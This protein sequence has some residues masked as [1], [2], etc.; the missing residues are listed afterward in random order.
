MR[1]ALLALAL[2]VQLGCAGKL[3]RDPPLSSAGSWENRKL[4]EVPVF[5]YPTTAIYASGEHFTGE[6]L[7]VDAD[8]AWLTSPN[9]DRVVP[10]HLSE[11][12]E[13]QVKVRDNY[14][15]LTGVWAG[16]GT[17]STL[18]QG[19][20]LIF[21]A[22]VWMLTGIATSVSASTG[23]WA[24]GLG[25]PEVTQFARFPAGLPPSFWSC[26]QHPVGSSSR[27]PAGGVAPMA[28]QPSPTPTTAPEPPPPQPDV[29]PDQPPGTPLGGE[30]I[31]PPPPPPP[32]P[33]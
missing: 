22:P 5:G 19:V 6:L 26:T 20:F 3:T 17:V 24:N 11:L 1:R 33:N 4:E 2:L 29:R 25:N 13:L 9:G 30:T 14:G 16:L 31:P 21:G 8:H 28:P 10:V 7:A 32:P 27:L 18:S 15:V 12:K 23:N